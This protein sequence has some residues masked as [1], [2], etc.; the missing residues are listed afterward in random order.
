MRPG[1]L[2]PVDFSV[3]GDPSQAAFW[4][5][6]ACITPGSDLAVEYVY[7]GPG[8][9]GFLDVLARMGADLELSDENPAS[10]TATVR[11]RYRPLRATRWEV[12]RCL[13]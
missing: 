11:A 9:A 6:A 8:R 1:P 3:P 5:V 12:Q 4:I 2:R 10:S 13:R 7:I